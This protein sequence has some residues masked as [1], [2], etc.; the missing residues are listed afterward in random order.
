MFAQLTVIKPYLHAQLRVH[1]HGRENLKNVTKP[2]IVIGNHSSHI[3]A[4][5]IFDS[6]PSK[7]SRGLATGVAA[8]YWFTSWWRSV[9]TGLLFNSYPIDRPSKKS[10]GRKGQNHRG[11]TGELLSRGV[12]ILVFPEGTRSRTGALGAFNPGA[13]ALSISRNA[14]ILPVAL[15]G[16]Y[17][18]W[19]YSAN[20]IA[21]GRPHVHVVFGQPESAAPG[22]IARE[23]MERLRREIV[24]MHDATARAN[25]MPTLDDYARAAHLR[26]LTTGRITNNE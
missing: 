13:A 25:D 1:V 24:A 9:G 5:A 11:L 7:L 22:E 14:P 12:P 21:P 15:V 3:D 2:F 16:N 20:R 8:D 26:E 23:F 6:L 17:A 19:P 18:A 4:L 10:T